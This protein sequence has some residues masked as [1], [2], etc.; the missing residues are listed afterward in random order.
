MTYLFAGNTKYIS[1]G[2]RRHIDGKLK[3]MKGGKVMERSLL[4]A[5][6]LRSCIDELLHEHIQEG[7]PVY[8]KIGDRLMPLHCIE[9]QTKNGRDAVILSC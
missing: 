8:I 2:S 3:T 7:S 1:S 4:T 5:E 9:H 6:D